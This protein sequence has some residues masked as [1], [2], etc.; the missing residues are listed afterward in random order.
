[1]TNREDENIYVMIYRRVQVGY[2]SLG[3]HYRDLVSGK[4]LLCLVR[5][6]RLT[7]LFGS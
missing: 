7:H 6:R 5:G 3:K 2:G 4:R 1:L